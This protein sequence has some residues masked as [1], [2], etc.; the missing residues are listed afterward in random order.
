MVRVLFVEDEHRGVNPYFKT[1]ESRGFHCT[2]TRDGD[3]AVAKLQTGEFN[4]VSL[5]V[6]FDPGTQA[7]GRVDPR[8]AGLHL[9]ELIRT[10][11][12]PNCDP[13]TKVIVL[14]A[15]VNPQVEER[16]RRLG[17]IDYLKKPV[18]FDKFIDTFVAAGN[19]T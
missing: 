17:V 13:R 2:L 12:I 3:E 15:V 11:K 1:L 5:D 16:M 10:N 19:E 8:R 4:M 9:L 7:G 14:T 18:R 6:M